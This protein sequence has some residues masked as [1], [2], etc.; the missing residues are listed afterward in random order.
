MFEINIL[1]IEDFISW[2]PQGAGEVLGKIS[3]PF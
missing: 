2:R 1:K 3:D